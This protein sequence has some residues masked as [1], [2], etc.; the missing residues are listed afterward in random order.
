MRRNMNMLH[1][2]F[3]VLRATALSLSL[4]FVMGPSPMALAA[5]PASDRRAADSK[6]G[7]RLVSAPSLVVITFCNPAR[8]RTSTWPLKAGYGNG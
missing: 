8:T 4:M 7:G 3:V 2:Y 5:Q 1:V 6:R